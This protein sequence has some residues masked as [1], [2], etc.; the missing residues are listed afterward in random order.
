MDSSSVTELWKTVG[1][2]AVALITAWTTIRV[3]RAA[4]DSA[5]PTTT[6]LDVVTVPT[7]PGRPAVA[8]DLSGLPEEL[9]SIVKTMADTI[10]HMQERLAS[11]SRELGRLQTVEAEHSGEL[12]ELRAAQNAD[13]ERTARQGRRIGEMRVAL[14]TWLEWA[15]DL[16][17]DWPTLRLHDRPP[18]LPLGG[19]VLD[20]DD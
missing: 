12:R 10:E 8:I 9:T 2:V 13:A 3:G 6:P 5:T 4:K 20:L 1:V 7:P 16:H 15:H 11:Q 14:R 19:A 18:E 17:Q